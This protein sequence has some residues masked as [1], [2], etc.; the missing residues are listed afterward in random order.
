MG[1][2]TQV[3]KN[4]EQTQGEIIAEMKDEDERRQGEIIAELKEED[5]QCMSKK[6]S[7]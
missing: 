7:T 4:D 5:E 6:H 3:D 1:L 2:Q